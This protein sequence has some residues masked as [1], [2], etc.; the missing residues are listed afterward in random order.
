MNTDKEQEL[1]NVNFGHDS[2][3]DKLISA[4]KLSEWAASTSNSRVMEIIYSAIYHC[5]KEG[6]NEK[7]N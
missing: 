2:K 6:S 3:E 5:T 4:N 7:E 1:I